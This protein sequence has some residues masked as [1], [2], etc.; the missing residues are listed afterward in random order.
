M[1]GIRFCHCAEW[2]RENCACVRSLFYAYIY[3]YIYIYNKS[4]GIFMCY[5]FLV[6]LFFINCQQIHRFVILTI[7]CSFSGRQKSRTN[8]FCFRLTYSVDILWQW[9]N[10]YPDLSSWKVSWLV[11]PVPG[12][13]SSRLSA[14]KRRVR[15]HSGKADQDSSG[16]RTRPGSFPMIPIVF[17]YVCLGGETRLPEWTGDLDPP[18]VGWSSTANE[19]PPSRC[20]FWIEFGGFFLL[21]HVFFWTRIQFCFCRK[22]PTDRRALS[23]HL[24]DGWVNLHRLSKHKGHPVWSVPRRMSSEFLWVTRICIEVGQFTKS[25]GRVNFFF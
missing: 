9:F 16:I 19:L 6:H 7:R 3:I 21:F 2:S 8:F 15:L 12:T 1:E 4:N 11:P 20:R 24:R 22:A 17:V 5:L 14:S 10:Y 25:A 18:T 13:G 23:V